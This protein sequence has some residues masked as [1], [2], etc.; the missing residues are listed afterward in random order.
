MSRKTSKTRETTRTIDLAPGDLEVIENVYA[1]GH[2]IASAAQLLAD[3]RESW[4]RQ[5]DV[6]RRAWIGEQNARLAAEAAADALQAEISRLT[7]ESRALE[8]ENAQLMRQLT[9][10]ATAA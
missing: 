2:T 1:G 6:E 9:R 8:A 3:G 7:Q 10:C 5:H 4:K